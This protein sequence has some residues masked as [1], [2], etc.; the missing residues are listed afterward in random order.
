MTP[1]I[2]YIAHCDQFIHMYI[3]GCYLLPLST[4]SWTNTYKV[5]N[6]KLGQ[7][8][9]KTVVIIIILEWN[10]MRNLRTFVGAYESN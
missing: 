9:I 8:I 2:R 10:E 1:S 7:I 4:I 5:R 3:T 6:N